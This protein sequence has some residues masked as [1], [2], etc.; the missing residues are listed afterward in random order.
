MSQVYVNQQ[1]IPHE[2][3]NAIFEWTGIRLSYQWTSSSGLALQMICGYFLGFMMCLGLSSLFLI[4][5]YTESH[6]FPFMLYII[7]SSIFYTLEYVWASIY[8]PD[9]LNVSAFILFAHSREFSFYSM[10]DYKSI[11]QYY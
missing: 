3:I 11:I 5:N 2:V 8:H 1:Y 9:T 6:I 4:S 7:F 10:F